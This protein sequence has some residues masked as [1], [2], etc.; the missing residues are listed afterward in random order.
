MRSLNRMRTALLFLAIMTLGMRSWAAPVGTQLY[1]AS[2]GNDRWSGH[3]AAPNASRT[4]GPFATPQ[5][6]QQE[7]HALRKGGDREHL[8]VSLRGGTYYLSSPLVFTSQNSGTH[9]APV[10]YAAYKNEKSVLSGGT[11]LHLTWTPYRDGILQAK[12]PAGM[13][14]DQLF[15]NGERQPMARYPNFDPNQRILNGY[16]K[17]AFSPERARGWADPRGGFMHVMH[18]AMWGDM[19]YVITGKNDRG[20]LTY[21]GGWQNNRPAPMHPE[22]RFVENIFEELDAPGEWFHNTKTGILYFYPPAGLNLKNAVVESV[23]LRHL[24]EFQGGESNPVRFVTLRGLTFR[25][26]ARTF[27]ENKEPLLRSDWTT[28]RGGAIFFNGA[29]DCGLED[30]FLDQLG[31]NGVFVS[32]YNRRVSVRG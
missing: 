15:V 12:A 32:D 17:D 13:V 29:E 3:L 30:C 26:A 5:R 28:Y 7:V 14:T 19:H 11:R 9:G 22:Y 10:V 31:G 8:T 23:R 20:E 21:E 16:A 25:H 1:V 27:M 24:V 6:A 18:E 2:N 4:D